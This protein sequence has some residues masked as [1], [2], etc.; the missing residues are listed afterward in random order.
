M[1]AKGARAL[2]RFDGPT[3]EG[4]ETFRRAPENRPA[5]RNKFRASRRSRFANSE[6]AVPRKFVALVV[7]IRNG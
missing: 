3:H 4:V 2:A 7:F 5:K 6:I 1:R